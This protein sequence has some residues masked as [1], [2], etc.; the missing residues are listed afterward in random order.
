MNAKDDIFEETEY[1]YRSNATLTVYRDRFRRLQTV[2]Q[3]QEM[4]LVAFTRYAYIQ[5]SHSRY[6]GMKESQLKLD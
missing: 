1:T 4:L 3:Q 2:G 6:L 5:S